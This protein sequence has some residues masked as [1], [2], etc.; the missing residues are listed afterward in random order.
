MGRKIQHE[1]KECAI[2]GILYVPQR[3]N[4]KVCTSKAC[5]NRYKANMAKVKYNMEKSLPK[6]DEFEGRAKGNKTTKICLK[7][8]KTFTSYGDWICPRCHVINR[9]MYGA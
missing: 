1:P 3:S 6:E 8:D 7:C 9:L 5:K 2:C 4:Q